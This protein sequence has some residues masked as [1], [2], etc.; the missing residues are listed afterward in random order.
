MYATRTLA[1]YIS[2]AAIE[3]LTESVKD[4]TLYCMLDLITAAI[5]GYDT[6][7]AAAVRRVAAQVFGA[8][9]SAVWFSGETLSSTGAALCN[10]AA[11]SALD[12]DD[13]HRAARGH[14]G[15]AVIPAALAAAAD[16][17]CSRD[18]ILIAISLGYEVSVRIA[19]AQNPNAIRSR[20]SGRW[21]GYGAVAAAGRLIGTTPGHLSHALAI[22]GVL[23]PNQDA[24][25]SSGYS[26]L[27]GNDVKEGIPWSVATGLTALRLA[28]CGH[29][30]PEDILDH[31]SHFDTSSILDHLAQPQKILGTYFKPYSCC[32]YI[33][34]AIDAFCDLQANHRVTHQEI[35]EIEVVIFAWA[36]QLGNLVYPENLTDIQYS[37]P[38]CLA[39][40]AIEGSQ[41]LAPIGAHLLNRPD[42][43]DCARRV[44]L[45]VDH[46]IDRR[47]P[48]ETLARVTIVSR[49]G[50]RLVSSVTTP[51]GDVKRPMDWA[52]VRQKFCR[53]T[54]ARLS[55]RRQQMLLEGFQE[56]AVGDVEG[57][58]GRLGQPLVE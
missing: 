17:A 30:G 22:A 45:S 15:A 31:A 3:D 52:E 18:E 55:E 14:P 48:A 21:V 32:R 27:T 11:A 54:A 56:F 12:L 47:F 1:S 2:A 41:A 38:Y 24:N 28:E 50:E 10:A 25:G 20:Q 19:A 6:G 8:G 33:H 36:L 13:G 58:L 53:I 35:E 37:L 44:H 9:S 7:S 46:E 39:I 4:K 40:A 51:R 49:S 57:L 42:L 23:A 26:Q 29:T 43:T 34:P 5:V 16:K